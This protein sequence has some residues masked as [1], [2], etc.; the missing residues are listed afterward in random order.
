MI[1]YKDNFYKFYTLRITLTDNSEPRTL[2]SNE[3]ESFDTMLKNFPR[4]AN[5]VVTPLIPTVEQQDRLEVLNSLVSDN[6]EQWNS[7]CI[8]FVENG[9]IKEGTP[10]DF[11]ENI[12][13][14]Y[15]E[16]TQGFILSTLSAEYDKALTEHL[17]KVAQER[18]YDNRITCALRAGFVGAFQAEGQA[19]ATWMDTCNVYAYTVLTEVQ[20]GIRPLPE[21]TSAFIAELPVLNWPV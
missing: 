21:S 11:L 10:C 1:Y 3:R 16:I 15:A 4:L 5:L 9:V 20:S 19:F 8:Q 14:D 17:D 7:E 6:K 18:R 2:Y 12:R 13:L